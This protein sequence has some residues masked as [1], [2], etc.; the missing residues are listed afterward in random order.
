MAQLATGKFSASTQ[1]S[2]ADIRGGGPVG[3]RPQVRY[4]CTY[5]MS[6]DRK[7]LPYEATNIIE[8]VLEK[9]LQSQQYDPKKS[10]LW[11]CELADKIKTK[12]KDLG[13]LRYKIVALVTIG[14]VEHGAVCCASQCV[15]NDKF[16]TYGE[17]TYRNGSL[18]AVGTVYGIYQE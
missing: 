16:D 8:D 10:Q 1:R 3:A 17:Y 4:E 2:G 11:C 5:K 18:Y 15:W 9:E 12:V 7:F 13:Y 14:S 6:P